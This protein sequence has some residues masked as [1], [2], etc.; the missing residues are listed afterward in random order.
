MK[1]LRYTE[2]W[3]V[4][5]PIA[6]SEGVELFDLEISTKGQQKIT[7]YISKPAGSQSGVQL[8]DCARVNRRLNEVL[9]AE[10][11]LAS[12]FAIEVSSPGINRRLRRPEHF[13]GAV[14]ERIVVKLHNSEDGRKTFRG[15]LQ[16]SDG[17][18][19]SLFDEELKLDVEVRLPNIR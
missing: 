16:Q 17:D 10:H 12:E 7:V 19:I 18:R 11:D 13:K 1:S 8:D 4:I 9:D 2:L 6:G 15:V 3:N 14:G 5:E